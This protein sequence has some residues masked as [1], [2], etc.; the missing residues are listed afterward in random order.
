MRRDWG[1]AILVGIMTTATVLTLAVLL[2]PPPC[3]PAD[4]YTAEQYAY[5]KVNGI[6][7]WPSADAWVAIFT[8]LLVFATSVQSYLILRAERLTRQ[9]LKVSIR[10]GIR[11]QKVAKQQAEDTQAQIGLA[12]DQFA[13]VNRTWLRVYPVGVGPLVVGADGQ[14]RLEVSIEA[15]NVGQHPAIGVSLHVQ[16]YRGRGRIAG[17]AEAMA[18]IDREKWRIR[19]AMGGFSTGSALLPGDTTRT[20]FSAPVEVLPHLVEEADK[21]IAL[22]ASA[23]SFPTTIAVIFCVIYRSLASDVLYHTG[24]IMSVRLTNGEL[25]TASGSIPFDQ[26]HSTIVQTN[27]MS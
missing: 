18:M 15:K 11:A 19:A 20:N 3:H 22:G 8:G 7:W 1:L 21:Y 2:F 5:C 27:I 4:H 10:Q 12:R 6:W 14:F 9:A 24:Q 16:F 26:L 23:A 13:A 25:E 17:L